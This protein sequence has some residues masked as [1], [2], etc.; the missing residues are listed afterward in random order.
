MDEKNEER[1]E[2]RLIVRKQERKKVTVK[3]SCGDH[4]NDQ[5]CIVEERV[6]VL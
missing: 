6:S 4:R 5:I 3:S 2:R 1:K